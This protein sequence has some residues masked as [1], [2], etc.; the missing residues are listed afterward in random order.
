MT[1]NPTAASPSLAPRRATATVRATSTLEGEARRASPADLPAWLRR[2]DGVRA[3]AGKVLGGGQLKP[4]TGSVRG[5]STGAV[6]AR[7]ARRRPWSLSP[8]NRPAPGEAPVSV[9]FA[10]SDDVG[11]GDEVQVATGQG[12][13]ERA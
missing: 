5:R 6:V 12:T 4:M 13:T 8:A 7:D 9:G 11:V 10:R 3:V 2:L 1:D